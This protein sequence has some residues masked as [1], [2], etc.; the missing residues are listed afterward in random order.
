M[1][2]GIENQ[3]LR[4]SPRDDAQY[5]LQNRALKLNEQVMKTRWLV[6]AGSGETIPLPFLIAVAFWL[7]VIFASI[8]L[9]APGNATVIAVLFVCAVSVASSTFLI[10]ELNNAYEVLMK[11]SS[12]PLRYTVSHLAR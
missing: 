9:F 3:I 4:L 5:W 6:L 7:T 12:E 2:D 1:I 8:G 10:L 11:V